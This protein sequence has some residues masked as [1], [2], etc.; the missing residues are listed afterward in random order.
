MAP[1]N[2]ADFPAKSLHNAT[3]NF[4]NFASTN[5]IN[6]LDVIAGCHNGYYAAKPAIT[7]GRWSGQAKM[8]AK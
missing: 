1:H 7:D 5:N 2:I 3:H 6:R 8:R 4:L